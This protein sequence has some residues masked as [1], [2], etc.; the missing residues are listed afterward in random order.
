MLDLKTRSGSAG[1]KE[2]HILNAYRTIKFQFVV[3]ILHEIGHIFITHL[4]EGQ[5]KTPPSRSDEPGEAGFRL[6]E[7]V[8]GGRLSFLR[9]KRRLESDHGV[10][11]ST[12][13]SVQ[14]QLFRVTDIRYRPGMSS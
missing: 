2:G 12:I 14:G 13:A 11:Q 10:C 6:E 7:L 5:D 8:F 9:D 1:D 4:G 3:T